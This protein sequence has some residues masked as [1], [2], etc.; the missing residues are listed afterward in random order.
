MLGRL[1]LNDILTHIFT[2]NFQISLANLGA[3]LKT[4]L[5]FYLLVFFPLPDA[6]VFPDLSNYLMKFNVI[7]NREVIQNT[8]ESTDSRVEHEF[9][10][11]SQIRLKMIHIYEITV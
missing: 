3:Y 10:C 5:T 7:V 9:V 4:C 1:T 8:K 11:F 6:A 2:D